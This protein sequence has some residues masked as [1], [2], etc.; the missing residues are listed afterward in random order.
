MPAVCTE[1]TIQSQ[2]QGNHRAQAYVAERFASE[3]GR[4]LHE[5]Q[6]AVVNRIQAEHRPADSLEIAAGPGR[7]TRDVSPHGRL[8]CL[9][10]NEGMIAEGKAACSPS[11]TWVQGNAFE[12]PFSQNRFDFVYT[13]RFVRHFKRVDRDRLHAQIRRVLRPGGV[14]VCDA[15]NGVVSAPLR[16]ANPAEYPVYDKLYDSEQDLR[17]EL[18]E[19]GFDVLDAQPVQRWY[20]AQYRAQVWLGPRSRWLTRRAIWLLERMRRGPALEWIATCRRV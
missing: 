16:D 20:G 15:V 19:A 14:F 7:L 13:F 11:V 9:E 5:R 8:T 4:L 6:I 10:Y 18:A 2:Y 3:L 1:A 12:L 17:A